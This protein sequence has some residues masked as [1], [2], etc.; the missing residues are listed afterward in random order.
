MRTVHFQARDADVTYYRRLKRR[1]VWHLRSGHGLGSTIHFGGEPRDFAVCGR[2]LTGTM[3]KV[4]RNH[5]DAT[6]WPC[7]YYIARYIA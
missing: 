1:V 2:R 6:C 7:R 5:R 4:T 3:R